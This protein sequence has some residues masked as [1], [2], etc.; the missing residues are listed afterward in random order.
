M[1]RIIENPERVPKAAMT[2]QRVPK[3]TQSQGKMELS[4]PVTSVLCVYIPKSAQSLQRPVTYEDV[5][6]DFTNEEWACLTEKQKILYRKVQSET[7][8]NLTFVGKRP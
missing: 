6:V 1:V 7:F 4:Y 2:V 8:K 3:Q 5:A